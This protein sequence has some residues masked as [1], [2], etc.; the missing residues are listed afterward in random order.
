MA[1][2]RRMPSLSLIFS[3]AATYC[4]TSGPTLPFN[5]AIAGCAASAVLAGMTPSYLQ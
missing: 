3:R 2:T 5:S 1:M 4:S